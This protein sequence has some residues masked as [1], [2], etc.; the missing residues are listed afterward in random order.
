AYQQVLENQRS[1]NQ[2]R[3]ELAIAETGSYLNVIA[4]YQA[5]GWGIATPSSP[6]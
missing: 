3:Q 4:L 5:L 1:L 6:E 2:T